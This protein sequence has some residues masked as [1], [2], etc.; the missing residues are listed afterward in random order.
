MVSGFAD[1]GA[2]RQKVEES[3]AQYIDLRFADIV[4]HWHTCRVPPDALDWKR[5]ESEGGI[6]GSSIPWRRHVQ[7]NDALVIPDPESAFLD[8]CAEPATLALICNIR[9]RSTGAAIAH[10]PRAIA[11]RTEAYLESTQIGGAARFSLELFRGPDAARHTETADAHSCADPQDRAGSGGPISFLRAQVAA[12]LE[13]AGIE[14]E[15][16]P[17]VA[18]RGRDRIV[19]RPVSLTRAADA[20]MVF[21]HAVRRLMPVRR[22]TPGFAPDPAFSSDG[23]RLRVAQS[24]WRADRPLFAGHGYLG[25]SAIMRHYLAGLVEHATALIEVLALKH[26]RGSKSAPRAAWRFRERQRRCLDPSQLISI[27]S[28][29]DKA[30]SLTFDC[31]TASSNP[32]LGLA[33]MLLAG[34]DGFNNRLYEFDPDMPIAGFFEGRAHSS[35]D[36]LDPSRRLDARYDF[37]RAERLFAPDIIAALTGRNPPIEERLGRSV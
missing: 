25:T 3:K 21:S 37:L 26:R 11:Q 17:A 30:T 31:L 7:L 19:L 12:R 6:D 36:R 27:A 14:L 29:G 9:D 16:S 20:L 13:A 23:W 24:L 28:P 33:A 15:D 35:A 8:P 32:Y 2:V 22:A 1:R 18:D 10:D 5:I 34:I 4:G